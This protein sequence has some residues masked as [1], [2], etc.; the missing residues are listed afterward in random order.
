M[1]NRRKK[2]GDLNQ[3]FGTASR[4]RSKPA[5]LRYCIAMPSNSSWEITSSSRSNPAGAPFGDDVDHALGPHFAIAQHDLVRR[6]QALRLV[7]T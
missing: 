6:W 2:T 5:T 4:S 7:C 3:R 1:P